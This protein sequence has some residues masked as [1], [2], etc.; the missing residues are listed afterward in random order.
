M[1]LLKSKQ[2]TVYMLIKHIWSNSAAEIITLLCYFNKYEVVFVFNFN[3]K[4]C[5]P[6]TQSKS[7]LTS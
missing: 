6:K 1:V 5:L 3:L 7:S 4:L 2:V